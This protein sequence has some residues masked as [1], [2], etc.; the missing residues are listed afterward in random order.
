[1]VEHRDVLGD[2]DRVGR[3]QHD[4]ELADADALGLHR[5][6]QIE[7]HRVVGDLEPLDVEMVFGE[8]DRVVAEVVGQLD[9]LRTVPAACA[10][11]GPAACPAMPGLDLGAAADAGQVEQRCLHRYAPLSVA[12]SDVQGMILAL[13][14][15]R[16]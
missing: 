15:T 6:V 7:Q 13:F 11:T 1:M 16:G 2:A 8:A 3:R 14:A 4:A 10:G 5:E 9:L 12:T